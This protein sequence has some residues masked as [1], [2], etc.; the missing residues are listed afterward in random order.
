[1]IFSGGAPFPSFFKKGGRED[2]QGRGMFRGERNPKKKE[3]HQTKTTA[4]TKPKTEAR[5][6]CGDK[7]TY[8]VKIDY[9]WR[10]TVNTLDGKRLRI[11]D[12]NG[13]IR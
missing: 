2:L 8:R 9:V 1:V 13:G 7:A 11:S 6:H 4:D 10:G 12:S 3:P 5:C